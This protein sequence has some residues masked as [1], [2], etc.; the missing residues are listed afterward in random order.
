MDFPSQP[1]S[2]TG[3]IIGVG[4]YGI[5]YTWVYIVMD[6]HEH[7]PVHAAMHMIVHTQYHVYTNN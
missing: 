4:I 3:I 2:G 1:A 5:Y 7:S 6:L